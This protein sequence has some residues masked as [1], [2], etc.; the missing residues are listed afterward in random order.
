VK[1]ALKGLDAWK[2]CSA[3]AH[4]NQV[5]TIAASRLDIG[6]ARR[7]RAVPVETTVD[8][9]KFAAVYMTAVDYVDQAKQRAINRLQA[10]NPRCRPQ[11]SDVPLV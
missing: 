4:G 10:R 7:P 9:P 6:D 3:F 2:M 8:L 11:A 1:S 5:M